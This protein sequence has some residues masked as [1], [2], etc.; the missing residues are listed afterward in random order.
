MEEYKRLKT[1]M[2]ENIYNELESFW[3]NNTNFTDVQ[4]NKF[5]NLIEKINHHSKEVKSKQQAE[6]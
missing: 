5:I 2:D 3:V 1:Q 4:A 6:I